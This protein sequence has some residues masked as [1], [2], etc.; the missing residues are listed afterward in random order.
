MQVFL[1][2]HSCYTTQEIANIIRNLKVYDRVHMSPS[3]HPTS[4]TSILILSFQCTPKL[5]V[6]SLL[7]WNF[8]FHKRHGIFWLDEWI[9]A[10]QKGPCFAGWIKRQN[11]KLYLYLVKHH[12]M[13]AYGR[14]GGIA[15]RIN[16]STGRTWVIISRPLCPLGKSSRYS[17]SVRL[18]GP[19][20]LSGRCGAET[21]SRHSDGLSS[22]P[23]RSK[24]FL[25][26]TASR[27]NLGPTQT[28]IQWVPVFLPGCYLAGAW[29][30]PLTSI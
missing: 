3:S 5:A 24:I 1:E 4:G 21:G 8:R 28:P 19:Y 7:Y 25:F 17:F 2:T 16:F 15:P 10:P 9:P 22:I 11:V 13:K 18:S 14:S 27:P 20:R 26:S 23:D 30:W 6:I 29:S 12:T